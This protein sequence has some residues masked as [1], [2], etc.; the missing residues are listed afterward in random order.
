[1]SVERPCEN[2]V[3]SIVVDIWVRVACVLCLAHTMMY[4]WCVAYMRKY[5]HGHL[6]RKSTNGLL[7]QDM[8]NRGQS[9]ACCVDF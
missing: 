8:D 6:L 4:T 3:V 2:T 7:P 1:M 9:P 5:F